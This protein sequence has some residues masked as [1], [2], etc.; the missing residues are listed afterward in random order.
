MGPGG[1]TG[2]LVTLTVWVLAVIVVGPPGGDGPSSEATSP[3]G[4]DNRARPPFSLRLEGT[5]FESK[6]GGV[7]TEN[8]WQMSGAL[9]SRGGPRLRHPVTF[10]HFGTYDVDIVAKGVPDGGVWPVLGVFAVRNVAYATRVVDSAEFRTY[11]FEIAKVPEGR[12][13]DVEFALMNGAD[14]SPRALTIASVEIRNRPVKP[15]PA[16]ARGP[17][18]QNPDALAT[19]ATI[20]WWTDQAADGAVEYGVHPGPSTATKTH[21][22]ASHR[23]VVKL[24]DLDPNTRYVYRAKSDGVT[25]AEG[26]FRTFAS[27]KT[28]AP[29]TF[30]VIGDFGNGRAAPQ[31]VA[32]LIA[33]DDVQLLLTVGDNVYPNLHHFTVDK[34]WLDVYRV[35]NR[36]AFVFPTW[37]NHDGI[38]DG[39]KL[40][41]SNIFLLPRPGAPATDPSEFQDLFYSFDVGEV[42]FT[43]L[44]ALGRLVLPG[45]PQTAWLRE[46]LAAAD[47]RGMR[48]KVVVM[49]NT[50]YGCGL[51]PQ[52]NAHVRQHWS[53]IFEEYAVDVVFVGDSHTYARTDVRD[54][55]PPGGDGRATRYVITG[56][57]GRP[58]IPALRKSGCGEIA[59]SSRGPIY[60]RGTLSGDT[61]TLEPIGAM[62][63]GRR[64]VLE[65]VQWKKGPSPR[66]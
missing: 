52:T 19:T 65:T 21:D 64:V 24:T 14:G 30:A 17:I 27:P 59:M 58:G 33:A 13:R 28:A 60:V 48:W 3:T 7:A 37:G 44:Y 61:A 11:S 41:A 47:R 26:V 4:G 23:H 57:S 63:D 45:S 42:H 40:V 51:V 8:A 66:P 56:A 46:D 34:H 22:G 43:M 50:P 25:L 6:S 2:R 49:H 1:V 16:L 39:V 35:A 36:R 32:D 15:T 53:P 12:V 10:P 29:V 9:A 20:V 5:Q 18:V 31:Q 55:F 38:F 62:P 54:D